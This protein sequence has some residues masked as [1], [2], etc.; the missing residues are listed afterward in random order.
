MKPAGPLLPSV[1]VTWVRYPRGR[2]RSLSTARS[3]LL[4]M[5]VTLGATTAAEPASAVLPGTEPLEAGRGGVGNWDGVLDAAIRR[6]KAAR[7]QR[8]HRDL[9]SAENYTRSIATNRARLAQILG[10]RDP[11]VAFDSPMLVA[12]LEEPALVARSGAYDILRVRWP[13]FGEVHG[14][15]LLLEPRSHRAKASVV[16]IPDCEQTPEQLVGLQPGVDLES[17]FARHLAESGCRVIV[18]VLIDRA[19]EV[20]GRDGFRAYSRQPMTSREF[21]FRP[22]YQLGRHLIGYEVQKVLAAVDWLT[23]DHTPVGV[24][25]YGE[26][27]LLAF[28]AAAI[29]TRIQASGVSGYF[30]SREHHWSEPFD[31]SVFS[32]LTEFGDAEIATLILPR[33]LLIEACRTPSVS[34]VAPGGSRGGVRSPD[35]QTVR[36]EVRRADELVEGLQPPVRIDLIPSAEGQGRFGTPELLRAFLGALDPEAKLAAVSEDLMARGRGFDP[37]ARQVRQ[38]QELDRHNQALL[39][40]SGQERARFLSRLDSSSLESHLATKGPYIEHLRREILGRIET[41]LLPYG[42]RSRLR[43]DEPKWR[44][45]EVQLDVL[46]GANAFGLLVIPKL[47]RPGE[48]RPVVVCQHGGGGDPD[49]LVKDEAGAY[50]AFAAHLA[51][52]GFVTFS[53]LVMFPPPDSLVRKCNSVGLTQYAYIAAMHQQIVDW[54]RTQPF[55]APDRIGLYGLS[56][57]GKTAM[58]MPLLVDGYAMTVVSGDFNEW[59]WKTTTTD[60]DYSYVFQPEPYIFEF[61]LGSTYGYAEMA[62]LI[63][64]RP[65]MVERGHA[66]PVGADEQVGLEF[67][68]VRRL[69]EAQ[70]RV[71]ENCDIEWFVGGHEIHLD[72]TLRF[73]HRHLDR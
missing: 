19:V 47:L 18:P 73:L 70:L 23:L 44:C 1:T 39:A 7:P 22:A 38:M 24:I 21:L 66:D 58:R 43:Y 48:R 5:I 56:W 2:R 65:F 63:A 41:P 55:V 8:W 71:P 68:K 12:T 17:Q 27:G 35:L 37:K 29:D 57:G 62:A 14:E 69:Y 4:W 61:N 49:Q 46:T 31:R 40:R 54:L 67:A 16:A 10:V 26:G 20:R 42:A 45:Y 11:R 32:L 13:A 34:V 25:G 51:E 15:G 30:D 59:T 3:A 72:Q 64:P 28:Y 60:S 50:H 52:E 53:P 36:S 6:A 9:S 33:R